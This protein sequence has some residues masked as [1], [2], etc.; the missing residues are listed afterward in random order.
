MADASDY[1]DFVLKNPKAAD[2]LLNEA[3][4]KINALS[5]FPDKFPLVDDPLLASWG[6]RFTLAKN[7]LIF[8]TVSDENQ[9]VTV[10]RFLYQKR[11]ITVRPRTLHFQQS[12]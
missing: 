3:E 10:V 11:N 6:I 2:E 12:P 5:S 8:Y 9:Q 7:Y 4:T 1:I